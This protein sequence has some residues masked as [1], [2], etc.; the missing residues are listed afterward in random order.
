VQDSA[1]DGW[2]GR[3]LL[4]SLSFRWLLVFDRDTQTTRTIDVTGRLRGAA[5]LP[6]G[7]LLVLRER[8]SP[9]A[10]DGQVIRLSPQ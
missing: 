2:N 10:E 9:D 4:N 3:Y 1:F 5:Q 8:T 6:S 7:D